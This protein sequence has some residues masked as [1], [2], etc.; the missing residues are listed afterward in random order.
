V[1]KSQIIREYK[2]ENPNAKPKEI[3]AAMAAA[4]VT[5]NAQ[6]VSTVLS[7]AKKKGGKIGKRHR[8]AKM[9]EHDVGNPFAGGSIVDNGIVAIEAAGA[10]LKA[11]G[12]V[13]A[14]RKTL[15]AIAKVMGQRTGNV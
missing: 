10:L 4:G 1:N 11:C 9:A 7:N 12:S 2:K 5:V 14:A 15:E 6:M 13:E 3:V 8:K